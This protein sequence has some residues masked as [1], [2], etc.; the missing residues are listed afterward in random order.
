METDDG[1]CLGCPPKS[2][3]A[4]GG[5]SQIPKPELATKAS[6][7]VLRQRQRGNGSRAVFWAQLGGEG[8]RNGGG[9]GDKCVLS[10]C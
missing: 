8:K 10:V 7:Q 3:Y 5:G 4:G 9:E 2:S 1:G 6:V